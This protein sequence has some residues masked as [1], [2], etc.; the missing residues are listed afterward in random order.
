MT[1]YLTIN[2]SIIGQIRA[3]TRKEEKRLQGT[4]QPRAAACRICQSETSC[5]ESS[6]TSDGLCGLLAVSN[7]GK[8]MFS[9]MTS[10]VVHGCSNILWNGIA[11]SAIDRHYTSEYC[12]GATQ[13]NPEAESHRQ[14]SHTANTIYSFWSSD[15]C[16]HRTHQRQDWQQR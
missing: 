5:K 13:E 2:F 15:S 3:Q 11:H 14:L 4:G 9:R 12:N 10:Y 6:V 7:F 8:P 1:T 16:P